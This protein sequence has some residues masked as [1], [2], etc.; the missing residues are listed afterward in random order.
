MSLKGYAQTEIR[1]GKYGL[2]MDLIDAL[3]RDK[4]IEQAHKRG[5][6]IRYELSV[7][8]KR[9]RS[10][11]QLRLY[12]KALTVLY[13]A[14]NGSIPT[15]D[16]KTDFHEDFKAEYGLRRPSKL[17][18]AVL[19]P[20]GL[21]EADSQDARHL[22]DC[23]FQELAQYRLSDALQSEARDLWRDFWAAGGQTYQGDKDFRDKA[24]LCAACG[25]AGQI[26]RAHKIGKAARPDLEF[27]SDNWIPLCRECHS[28]QHSIGVVK[29][30][31]RYP[32]LSTV[33]KK[34]EDLNVNQ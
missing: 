9:G 7:E 18:P 22:I 10:G 24:C 19:V 13:I 3:A 34:P 21:S 12:W 8:G 4:M 11:G 5:A 28:L 25:K 29:F 2:R 20:I 1:D 6:R 32:H 17:N 31:E 15:E 30:V 16:E 14:V 26:D 33:W 23:V 27:K